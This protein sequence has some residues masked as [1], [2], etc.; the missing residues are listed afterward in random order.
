MPSQG[1]FGKKAEP[2]PQPDTEVIE[3]IR[4]SRML[5][6]RY[7]TLERRT[8][9]IEENQLD[10]N[11]KLSSEIRAINDDIADI[12]KSIA[13]VNDKI[14]LLVTEMQGFAV[15]D[16]VQVIKKYLDYWEPLNFVTQKQVEKIA[17]E[18]FEEKNNKNL[19]K[20]KKF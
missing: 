8:Q 12:K 16:E 5:E 9:I 19:N 18:V 20:S 3:T 10:H 4:R 7:H 1:L 11:R 15:K 2:A 14:Q 13:E 6:E 17:K